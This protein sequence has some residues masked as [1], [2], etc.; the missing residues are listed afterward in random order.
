[1]TVIST[2]LEGLSLFQAFPAILFTK[3]GKHNG[4]GGVYAAW[5]E[6]TTWP[7]TVDKRSVLVV[8]PARDSLDLLVRVESMS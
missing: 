3:D 8:I 1:M 7:L 2:A 6:D 4:L 5:K